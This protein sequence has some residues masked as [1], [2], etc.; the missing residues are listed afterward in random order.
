MRYLALITDYDGAV[1]TDGQISM[2][3][4]SA[5]TRLRMSGRRAILAT[6]RRLDDLLAVCPHIHLF[7]YVVAENGA[8]VYAPRTRE[9]T[10]L[11]KR[12]PAEFIERL[13]SL[14]V[15]QIEVG[16][17]IVATWLPHHTAVLQAI[18]EMGLEL[19]V[20]FNRT[21]VMVLPAGVNK[22]TGLDYAL[23]KLGLSFHEAVGVGDAENDHSF[24]ERCECAVAVANAVPSIR[25]LAAFVTRG[26]AGQG[27]AELIDELVADDLARM[28]GKLQQHHIAVGLRADGTPVSVSPYGMN[29]LIA[30]PSG[31][32]KS[33]VTA[34]VVER[35]IEQS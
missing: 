35:L 9:E 2:D 28:Q 1:A 3:A 15:D 13:A 12:P 29:I 24:L 33:T 14:G 25:Q 34:G 23:R 22:A 7:D 20:I 32:G 19:L 18:Q 26:Q 6:G 8:V 30:G 17:V 31:S 11:G 5:L 27:V 21:A 16:R 10:M 4:V